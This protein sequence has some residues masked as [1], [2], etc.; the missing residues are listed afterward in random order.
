MYI[1]SKSHMG[2]TERRADAIKRV[3]LI[4]LKQKYV[5]TASLARSPLFMP[6]AQSS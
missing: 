6:R 1:L 3:I 5:R 2:N 4:W